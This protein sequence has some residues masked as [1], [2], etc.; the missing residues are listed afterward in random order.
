MK[1]LITGATGYIG[2]CLV[3]LIFLN[4][5]EVIVAARKQFLNNSP[6]SIFFDLSLNHIS[7]LP[8]GV[9]AVVHLAANTTQTNFKDSDLEIAAA[10]KLM[11]AAKKI[12]AKFIFVSS[13][14]ARVDAPTLYGKTKYQIEQLVLLEGG[15]VVRPGLVYGGKN[16]GLFGTLVNLVR[17]LPILP[18]FFP[19]PYVQ[20]IHVED[21]SKGLLKLIEQQ[22]LPMGIYCLAAPR[23]ISFAV[24]L[25]EIAS[26]RLYCWRG[27]V[28]VPTFFVYWIINL[29]GPIHASRLGLDRLK[30]LFELPL[31]NTADDLN[32]L[33]IKL[34]SLSSG[35]HRSGNN[36]RRELLRESGAMFRYVLNSSPDK[37]LIRRYVRA[38]ERLR[39]GCAIGLPN[40]FIYYPKT[41]SLVDA[42]SSN[43]NQPTQE[44]LWRLDAATLL[45]EAST[46]G[47]SRF[48]GAG[49]KD[50]WIKSALLLTYLVIGELGWRMIQKITSFCTTRF[51][52]PLGKK[53]RD[54]S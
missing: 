7:E 42:S 10:K 19:I 29:L 28:V 23:P 25:K 43:T 6:Q 12:D 41:I 18:T 44:F 20:P 27:F 45:A 51:Y 31:M 8:N 1:V 35:M 38:I 3:D 52:Y 16:Q 2:T 26:A 34:R 50:G 15:W 5:H 9:D 47:A 4:G 46:Q 17:K 40:F 13:Q 48:L 14:S 33:G 24:F 32:H 30:A 37:D 21:L 11:N 36:Q 49:Q 39:N 53:V 22:D 54:E